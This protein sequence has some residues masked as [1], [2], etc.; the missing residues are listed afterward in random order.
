MSSKL[1]INV[2]DASSSVIPD[3]SAP[4][5]GPAKRDYFAR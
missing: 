4:D 2:N 5:T 1:L 3:T